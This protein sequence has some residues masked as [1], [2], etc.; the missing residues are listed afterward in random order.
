MLLLVLVCAEGQGVI[1]IEGEGGKRRKKE[2]QSKRLDRNPV[3][4]TGEVG[5][6]RMM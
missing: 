2:V 6:G 3:Y 4:Y 5:R 1:V